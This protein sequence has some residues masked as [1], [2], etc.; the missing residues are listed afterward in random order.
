MDTLYEVMKLR[1]H[2]VTFELLHFENA[3]GII[4]GTLRPFTV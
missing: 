3:S 1:L 4:P 2:D